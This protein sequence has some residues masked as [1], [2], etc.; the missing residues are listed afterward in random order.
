MMVVRPGYLGTADHRFGRR[1]CRAGRS[2]RTVKV[3]RAHPPPFA[4]AVQ[5]VQVAVVATAVTR[6]FGRLVLL[7]LLLLD[8]VAVVL[9]L[10]LL[11]LMMAGCQRSIVAVVSV[12]RFTARSIDNAIFI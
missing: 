9:L 11:L 8:V 2:R 4:S 3:M 12:F 7:L 6:R 1:G 10:L 5:T